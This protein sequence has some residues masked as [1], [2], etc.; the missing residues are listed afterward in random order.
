MLLWARRPSYILVSPE[1]TPAGYKLKADVLCRVVKWSTMPSRNERVTM[2]TVNQIRIR[3]TAAAVYQLA[4]RVEEWPAILSHYRWVRRLEGDERR[5]TVEMAARRD[6]IPVKWTSV[7]ECFPEEPRLR[8]THIRGFTSGMEVE[9]RFR[10]EGDDVVV[11]ILHD[12]RLPWPVIGPWVA[13]RVVGQFFVS[14]IA[15]KTLGR[16]KALVEGGTAVPSAPS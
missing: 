14:Y 15:N 7:L 5:R 11:T 6:W 13:Q 3:G 8:F 2:H 12:F 4:S 9:W 10:E 16:M 1:A